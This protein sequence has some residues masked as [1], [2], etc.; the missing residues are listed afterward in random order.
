MMCS[1]SKNS[2]T[3]LER[4][5]EKEL[6]ILLIWCVGY[7]RRNCICRKNRCAAF[8]TFHAVVRTAW[9]VFFFPLWS[10]VCDL[11][12]KYSVYNRSSFLHSYTHSLGGFPTCIKTEK[13]KNE[14]LS[15]PIILVLLFK[16]LHLKKQTKKIITFQDYSPF[17]WSANVMVAEVRLIF[18]RVSN[19]SSHFPHFLSISY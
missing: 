13:Y 17:V 14:Y 3:Y 15:F 5:A 7:L 16:M 1:E 10:F 19:H 9:N 8:T 4:M 11:K 6:L 12:V 2:W 18:G